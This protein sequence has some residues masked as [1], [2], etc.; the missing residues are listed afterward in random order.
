MAAFNATEYFTQMGYPTAP[1]TPAGAA[2]A[3]ATGPVDVNTVRNFYANELKGVNVRSA[4]AAAGGGGG[5]L[6]GQRAKL[7]DFATLRASGFGTLPRP[8]TTG[9]VGGAAAG[10]G[11]A[12]PAFGPNP[13]LGNAF[14]TDIKRFS[15]AA[16]SSRASTLPTPAAA[17]AAP[18]AANPFVGFTN[19]AVPIGAAGSA[20]AAAAG[21]GAGVKREPVGAAAGAGAGVKPEFFGQADSGGAGH[22]LIVNDPSVS[23][24]QAE[25]VL[26]KRQEMDKSYK[27]I[28]VNKYFRGGLYWPSTWETDRC[29]VGKSKEISADVY[30]EDDILR[31]MGYE[32]F[33]FITK[34]NNK[35]F[36]N[37]EFNTY[38]FYLA[39]IFSY[40]ESYKTLDSRLNLLVL[41][42]QNYTTNM[43]A[44][45]ARRQAAAKQKQQEA[46]QTREQQLVAARNQRAAAEQN[47][48]IKGL[49]KQLQTRQNQLNKLS[50]LKRAPTA[51]EVANIQLLQ[52]Q[53]AQLNASLSGVSAGAT[54][55]AFGL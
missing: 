35:E 33:V 52:Q 5:I 31:F 12:A 15:P 10:G 19:T 25:F 4:G 1:G 29:L 30:S 24:T 37:A 8:A 17:P 42:A 28:Q 21:A 20:G 22:V 32:P 14:G 54:P 43:D 47:K 46:K 6:R 11:A 26:A 40:P 9:I 45:I 49:E 13:N 51:N 34:S 3:A 44:V 7:A 2:A 50:N 41:A 27:R 55:M 38:C 23:R 36:N 16:S 48:L 18:V 39:Q 53:I